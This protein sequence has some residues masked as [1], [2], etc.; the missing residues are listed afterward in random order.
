MK[1]LSIRTDVWSESRKLWLYSQ[2]DVVSLTETDW[3]SWEQF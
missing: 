3:W 2:S 1:F